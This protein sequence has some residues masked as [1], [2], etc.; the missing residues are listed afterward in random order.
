MRARYQPLITLGTDEERLIGE[1]DKAWAEQKA[2]A[3]KYFKREHTDSLE[4][5]NDEN[6]ASF[7]KAAA[8]LQKDLEFNVATGKAVADKGTAVY[9][10][11]RLVPIGAVAGAGVICLLLGYGLVSGVSGPIR[12]MTGTM[13]RLAAHDLEVEIA[14][15]RPPRRDRRDGGG[16]AGVQGQS[17]QRR[18]AGR[19]AGGRAGGKEQRA[20]RSRRW[21]TGSRPRPAIWSPP[22][23]PP[24]PSW[25]PPRSRCLH[26]RPRPASRP[27]RS[28]RRPRRPR[29]RADRGRGR[30][31][32]DRLDRRDQ[33]AG[34]AIRPHRRQG[35][36]TRREHTDAIVQRARR[37]RAEDRRRGRPDHRTS[38]AR[39]TCWRSTPRSRRRA[40][41]RPAR[42]SPWSPRR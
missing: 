25:K 24:R 34:R 30:R 31:G 40:P 33:P 12:R 9:A 22:W 18:P 11:T 1:F 35:G 16:G 2:V 41:A 7:Q 29:Q 10:S 6:H 39:P 13:D 14:G 32:A 28:P 19:G 37:G 5:F 15:G 21:R 3:T 17:R 23:P 38:P 8:A 27:R 26:R 20:A 4:L 42:A 36:R